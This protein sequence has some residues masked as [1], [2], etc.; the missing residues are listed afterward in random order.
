MRVESEVHPG[1][2]P[3]EEI[4][5]GE[6]HD[7]TPDVAEESGSTDAHD[8][9]PVVAE[10]VAAKPAKEKA[11]PKSRK[12]AAAVPAAAVETPKS[13]SMNWYILKVQSN[14]EESIKDGLIRRVKAAGHGV[15]LI[16]CPLP[17]KSPWLNPIE[18]KWVQTKRAVVEPDRLLPARE[19]AERVCDAL[20]C[21][22][23]EHIPIPEKVA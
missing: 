12:A 6:S 23:H 7:E 14:R 13:E 4:A 16:I 17:I 5:H 18:P 9:E 20:G 11:A 8:E 10:P 21:T 2:D 22:Y 1:G 19:L 3:Q 15:R